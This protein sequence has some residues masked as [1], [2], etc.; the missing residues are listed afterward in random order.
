MND[1]ERILPQR[2][3]VTSLPF[4]D[5]QA[6]MEV[7]PI[8]I[9]LVIEPTDVCARAHKS[10]IPR[11][12]NV[13]VC[14]IIVVTKLVTPNTHLPCAQVYHFS[15]CTHLLGTNLKIESRSS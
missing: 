3:L 2:H 8:H 4:S 11:I 10:T 13:I 1:V 12:V 5:K 6:I 14:M 15:S 9:V 7:V